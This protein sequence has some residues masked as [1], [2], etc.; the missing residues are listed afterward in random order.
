VKPSANDPPF[1]TDNGS[2]FLEVQHL[3]KSPMAVPTKSRT[4]SPFVQIATVAFVIQ[5]IGNHL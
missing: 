2:P 4:P 1:Y 5:P 3:K